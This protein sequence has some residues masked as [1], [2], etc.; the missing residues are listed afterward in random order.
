M[1]EESQDHHL[2]CPS[3]RV[4][5]TAFIPIKGTSSSSLI[6]PVPESRRVSYGQRTTHTLPTLNATGRGLRRASPSRRRIMVGSRSATPSPP[7]ITAV[8]H[9]RRILASPP[10]PRISAPD[11]AH[12]LSCRRRP[13]PSPLEPSPRPPSLAPLSLGAATTAA[14]AGR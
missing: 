4:G 10:R 14:N 1:R 12:D 2:R 13:Q 7:R 6:F 9:R 3:T 8:R 11:T 5:K